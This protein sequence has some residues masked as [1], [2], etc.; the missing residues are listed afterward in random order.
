MPRLKTQ[1]KH[2]YMA[3][4]HAAENKKQKAEFHSDVHEFESS[5]ALIENESQMEK[6]NDVEE[7]DMIL[8]IL[9]EL[10]V[11]RKKAV[12]NDAAGVTR[13]LTEY[14]TLKAM[15]TEVGAEVDV[16]NAN[17]ADLDDECNEY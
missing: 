5:S 6:E 16:D 17:D 14:W 15:F 1:M 7:I 8:G 13:P 10:S 2:L 12:L 3:S 9:R 4:I 11:Q